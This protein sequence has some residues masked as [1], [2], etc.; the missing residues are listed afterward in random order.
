[1]K[2]RSSVGDLFTPEPKRWGL[3]GD[4]FLWRALSQRLASTA[5]PARFSDLA[6]TLEAAFMSETNRSLVSGISPF[7]LEQ[8]AHG[9]MSSGEVDPQ[10]WIRQ[11]LPLLLQ[12]FGHA[13]AQKSSPA[14]QPTEK[15]LDREIEQV[16]Q[17]NSSFVGWFTSKCGLPSES[18]SYAWSRSDHPWTSVE[19]AIK[20]KKSG[21]TKMLKCEGETDI[22]IIVTLGSGVRAALHIENKLSGGKFTKLQ[23]EMYAAR[24]LKWMRDPKY[25]NYDI[26][27]TVLIAPNTFLAKNATEAQKFD[28]S[29]SHEELAAYLP[30]LQHK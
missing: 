25:G 8:F 1:M 12:R 27:K 17:S 28:V 20:D 30:S 4:P 21:D 2:T 5:L 24:A 22:L 29:I 11:A 7:H 14:R 3:R 10:F 23:P 19:L 13:V 18:A 6:A 26:A 16:F 9:G 15:E